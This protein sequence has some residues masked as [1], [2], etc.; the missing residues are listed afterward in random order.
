MRTKVCF[1]G[2][3]PSSARRCVPPLLLALAAVRSRRAATFDLNLQSA[4][5]TLYPAPYSNNEIKLG[6]FSG[7]YPV[8]GESDAFYVITDRGPA[9]DFVDVDGKAYKAWAIP[10]FGPQL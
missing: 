9:P 2:W 5:F 10:G 6:G 8:P 7:I 3:Q 4:Q 1:S